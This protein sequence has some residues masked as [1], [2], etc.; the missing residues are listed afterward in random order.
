MRDGGGGETVT[1]SAQRRRAQR[2]ITRALGE[3]GLV[4]PGSVT[5]RHA[6]CGKANC[7]CHAEPPQLHGPYISWTRK[8]DNKTVTRVL[9]DEQ[10][11]DYQPWFDNARK[12]RALIAELE[13]L[14]LQVVEDDNRWGRK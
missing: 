7:R 14:S 10:L 11:R 3:I 4:L 12:L 2:R 13:T 1:P 5:T 9:S 8:V 6:R